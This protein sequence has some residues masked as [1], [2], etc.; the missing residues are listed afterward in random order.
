[1]NEVTNSKS[2]RDGASF[3]ERI[4]RP[5]MLKSGC[6]MQ[7]CKPITV[8]DNDNGNVYIEAIVGLEFGVSAL[9][10]FV[11]TVMRSTVQPDANN[12]KLLF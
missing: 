6:L 11:V 9:S 4:V 8:I 5:K 10:G 2:P 1:M 12:N 7:S 3:L